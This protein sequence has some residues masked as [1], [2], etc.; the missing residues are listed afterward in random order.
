MLTLFMVV[1][2]TPFL[3]F[4]AGFLFGMHYQKGKNKK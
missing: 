2:G 3:F 1:F 4:A